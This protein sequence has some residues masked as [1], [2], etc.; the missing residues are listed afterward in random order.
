[1]FYFLDFLDR[2]TE[3]QRRYMSYMSIDFFLLNIIISITWIYFYYIT[4]TNGTYSIYNRSR[5]LIK[6]TENYQFNWLFL[7][8]MSIN[9]IFFCS[10]IIIDQN[11]FVKNKKYLILF[12]NCCNK[13]TPSIYPFWSLSFWVL[14]YSSIS[15]TKFFLISNICQSAKRHN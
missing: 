7:S 8:I 1:M 12:Y 13:F 3:V 6:K 15:Y 11:H 5:A 4:C 2:T 10:L 14:N 9:I